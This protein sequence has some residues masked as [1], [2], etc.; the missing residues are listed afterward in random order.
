M[1]FSLL[2]QLF[3]GSFT[4]I[5]FPGILYFLNTTACCVFLFLPDTCI[6]RDPLLKNYQVKDGLPSSEVYCVLQDSKGFMWFSTD[7][8]VSRFDGY[9][10]ENFTA[11]NG[12]AD[13]TVFGMYEDRKGRIWFRSFSGKLCYY[14]NDS[15][16]TIA[17]NKEISKRHNLS[18]IT[19]LYVD[20]GDTL[21]CGISSGDLFF[22]KIYSGFK[23][24]YA[25]KRPDLRKK[26]SKDLFVIRFNDS[27]MIWGGGQL[28]GNF[29]PKQK[30]YFFDKQSWNTQSQKFACYSPWV[31]WI[32]PDGNNYYISAA[33]QLLHIRNAAIQTILKV[34]TVIAINTCR[35]GQLWLG[36]IQQGAYCIDPV[37]GETNRCLQGYTVTS[38]REDTEGGIWMTTLENGVFYLPYKKVWSFKQ[39]GKDVDKIMS[40]LGE[41]DNRVWV[42]TGNGA[43]FQLN[44]HT[45]IPSPLL[46]RNH[47]F[48]RI[49]NIA[50]S[51]RDELFICAAPSFILD[52]KTLKTTYV[53][54]S[55]KNTVY[56]RC[57][58][59]DGKHGWVGNHSQ[60][61]LLSDNSTRMI[62]TTNAP[63]R[64][65]TFC[66]DKHGQL[67]V[68][69]FNGLWRYEN[70]QFI[71]YGDTVELLKSRIEDIKC[72]SDGKL[73][74]ATRGRGI[75]IM[76][77]D[78]TITQL[79]QKDGLASNIAKSVMI[80]S[81]S[82]KV[83]AG[84]NNGISL[85]M[86][87]KNGTYDIRNFSVKNELLFK[88]VNQLALTENYIWAATN[89]GVI[90][91][92]KHE[93]FQ[94]KVP[95]PVYI[96]G[97]V[98]GEN[99][100]PHSDQYAL[101]FYENFVRIKYIGLSYKNAGKLKYRYRL[102]GIDST[103]SYTSNNFVQYTTLPPGNYIFNVYAI[104]NDGVE[105]KTPAIV[106]FMIRSPFWTEWWFVLLLFIATGSA[107]VLVF[108]LRLK[109]LHNRESERSDLKRRILEIELKALRAQMNPHFIFNSI[110][111]IQH[112]ILE[113]DT[114][115]AHKYLSKFSRLIRNVL[116]NS[117]YENIT[118]EQELDTLRLYVQLEE[119]RFSP[120]FTYEIIVDERIDPSAY[121]I[122]PMIIQPYI[123]NAIWHGLMH[124]EGEGKLIVQ[125]SL[126]HD[127]QMIRCTIDDNG[128]GRVK[129]AT[130][131][132]G[133][134]HQSLGLSV[135]RERLELINDFNKG[136]VDVKIIDKYDESGNA[137]GTRIEMYVPLIKEITKK[138]S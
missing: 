23:V 15:F 124:K 89:Q 103:W 138:R 95:P 115:T 10:F 54:Y 125:L 28:Y 110:N 69:C 44:Y 48:S 58:I 116:E 77:D 60:I 55:V 45:D 106:R 67:W 76:S 16:Y 101:D 27:G 96:K 102:E 25:E 50:K 118:I 36:T 65:N 98:I 81:L 59:T 35:D 46:S 32:E 133:K 29:G 14:F 57:F 73:W 33:E 83:W 93:D 47:A 85:I 82:G 84:T 114:D 72:A 20:E 79:T 113:N 128:I 6:A 11:E 112:F 62:A 52:T 130:Y 135:T 39:P 104:N 87:A 117:R 119:L 97:I 42:G 61:G 64:I 123:E 108:N 2:Q 107:I 49:N 137:T 43:F 26:Y 122:P 86:P 91:F 30:I 131:K 41:P 63:S 111:S 68:G 51:R 5:C 105:S 129:S 31:R 66:I 34:P 100:L 90:M 4:Y 9:H 19:S 99:T 126:L 24:L 134:S 21:W 136:N 18:L 120:K 74:I 70:R 94:N 121:L 75:L 1:I 17:A 3:R 132:K 92:D 38:I 78:Q 37:S 80:D 40:I 7:A 127:E 88:E 53:T 13:N 22:Y 71:F 56:T 8:G 12:L 109:E